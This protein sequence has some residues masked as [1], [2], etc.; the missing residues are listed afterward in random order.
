MYLCVHRL[1]KFRVLK[2]SSANELL[3]EETIEL[4]YRIEVN[5]TKQCSER[6]SIYIVNPAALASSEK[7]HWFHS[8][9]NNSEIV[10]F[11]RV[12]QRDSIGPVA[13]QTTVLSIWQTSSSNKGISI[14]P[15]NCKADNDHRWHLSLIR[16]V[17]FDP[18]AFARLESAT[19]RHISQISS[20]R[21]RR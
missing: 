9:S 8:S 6:T 4:N 1:R 21:L 13:F 16:P 17:S 18:P 19:S 10:Y 14:F 2:L 20:K 5:N 11:V 15:R 7:E 12:Q 3:K